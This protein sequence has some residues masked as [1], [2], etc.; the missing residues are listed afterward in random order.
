MRHY[1]LYRKGEYYIQ[2][3]HVMNK[4][5]A[6]LLSGCTP[7]TSVFCKDKILATRLLI[8]AAIFHD[9]E[10]KEKENLKAPAPTLPDQP[11][12]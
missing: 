6:L 10:L 12:A 1:L 8:T 7:I 4:I 9:K 2:S 5:T 3:G 11:A